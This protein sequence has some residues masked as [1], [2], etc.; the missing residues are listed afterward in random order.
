MGWCPPTGPTV[1]P[2]PTHPPLSLSRLRTRSL[3]RRITLLSLRLHRQAMQLARL[4]SSSLRQPSLVSQPATSRLLSHL[5]GVCRHS[6][7]ATLGAAGR[8]AGHVWPPSCTGAGACRHHLGERLFLWGVQPAQ[9]GGHVPLHKGRHVAC[10]GCV[11]ASTQGSDA[12]GDATAPAVPL[13]CRNEMVCSKGI[14]RA[15]KGAKVHANGVTGWALGRHN[16][17]YTV[18][19]YTAYVQV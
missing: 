4:S 11:C 1:Q 9:D 2:V 18:Y 15:A 16:P 19:T 12:C 10:K 7:S 17:R 13:S 6:R 8:R 3:L 5:Q 14:N